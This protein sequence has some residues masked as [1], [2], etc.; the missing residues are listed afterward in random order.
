MQPGLEHDKLAT[1]PEGLNHRERS[2]S[3]QATGRP[4]LQMIDFVFIRI[5]PGP[6]G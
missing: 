2:F 5:S 3:D 6:K 1:A 4:Y